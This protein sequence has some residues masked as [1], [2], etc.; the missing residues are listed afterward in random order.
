MRNFFLIFLKE[1]RT[2]FNSS[3]AFVVITIFL[4]LSGYFFYNIFATFSTLSFQAMTNPLVAQQFKELSIT[5]MVVRPFFGNLSVFMLIM[6]PMLTMRIFSEEKKSGTIELLLTYPVRDSEVIL[7]KFA[8]CLGIFTVML[9]LTLPCFAL[10]LVF[11]EPE[12]GVIVSGYFG[13]F[14]MGTA[15]ISLGVF[16]SSLTENQIVAAVVSFG[17]LLIFFMMGFSAGFASERIGNI[18]KHLSFMPHLS[19]FAK[20]V[21]DTEDVVYYLLFIFFCIFLNMRSLESKRW[22]G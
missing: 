5:E 14:L 17:F 2:Y 20:G 21:I 1:F 6:L 16:A 4:V 7:G 11:G 10:V 18:L 13:L 9:I 15:F 3:I 19:N 8:G 12:M 22:R